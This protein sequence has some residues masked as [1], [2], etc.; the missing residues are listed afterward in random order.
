MYVLQ[1]VEFTGM[2]LASMSE[3]TDISQRISV[4]SGHGTIEKVCDGGRNKENSI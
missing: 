4:L 1:T 3:Q 2:D